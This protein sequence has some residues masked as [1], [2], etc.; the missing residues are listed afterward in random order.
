M[1][2]AVLL[3]GGGTNLQALL[4]AES[5]GELAPGS[6]ELVLSNRAQALGVERAR[7]ASKPVAIVEH[8]DFAERAA[9]ED[10][11]LAHMREHRIEAVVLAGFMRILGARFVDAYAGRIINTHP[12]LLPA[13]PG[14]DAAAQAVAHGA[15]LSGA[16]VHFVDTGVDTGPIIAQRAVPVLDDDDAASL[17]ERIRAVEHALLP[18]VV[19]MLAAGELLCDGRRVRRQRAASV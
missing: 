19:R 14:V 16:T 8:G 5:R 13:F 9:F 4:D 15:K 18:E 10:A 17:H 12:S 6:I 11:L 2:C 1:R 3:S 7:R